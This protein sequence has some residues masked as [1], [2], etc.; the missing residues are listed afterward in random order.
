MY[1]ACGSLS[2]SRS[3]FDA[4]KN[5]DLF[6]Y[7]ALL[8]GYARNAL[9]RDAVSLF[10]DLLFSTELVPD[11]FTLPCV[12]KACAGLTDAELGEAIHALALKSGIFSDAFV[13]N[14]LIA[15][16]GKC[17][18]LQSAVKVFETMPQRNL[19]S[20]N[21][22]MC[23]YTENGDYRECCGVFKGMLSE[24]EGLVPDV[25]TMVT[26]I[27]AYAALGE[28]RV[29]MVLHGLAFKLG[30]SEEVMVNNSLVDMY[31]KC[32]CS[33]DARVLFEMNGGKNVV[34]WNT[35]IGGY[36]KE[37]DFLE[38]FGLLREMQREEKVKVNAVTVLNVLPACSEELLLPS[39]KELHGYAFRHEFQKD[40]LVANAFVAAYAKCGALDCAECVFCGMEGKTVSSWNAL[41][42][43]HAQNG[44]P[45]KALDLYLVMMDSGLDPDQFTIGSLLLACS[46]LKFIRCGKEI[47][48]FMLRNGLELDNF[49]RIS[50]L[51]LYIQCGSMLPAKLIFDK[52]DNKSLVCWNAMITGFSQN[53]LPCEAIDTFCQMLSS[54]IKPQ[55]VAV[56]GV[57][58]ACSRVSALRLGKELH[59]F[60]LKAHLSGDTFVTCALIDMYAKCG[61]M[62]Q[63][64]NIFDRVN[65]KDEAIW[66]V[67]IAGYGI[68]GQGLKAIELFQ[69]MQNK[70]CRPDSF[71][72]LG[73]L[74]AC[75]HAG[76]VTEGLKYLG[77]MQSLYGVKPKVEHYACVVDMLGR[78][79]RLNEALKLVN[80]MPDEPDSGIWSS[81]LSSCRNYGDLEIG[82]EVSKKLLELEPD[83]AENYVL[84]SNL[85][86]GLG[87]WDEVRNVR[88]RMKENRLHK[89]AGCSW[90]EIGG[91][92]YRFVV[93]DGSLLESK[94][95]QQTWIK[96]EKKISNIGYK[97]DTSCVL[98]E[99]EEEEK[100][101]ILK[102]HSE[103]LAISFG[104][105]NTA[106]G[107][108]LRVCKN[109]RICADCHS[110]IKLVSKVVERDIIVR[111]NKRFHHFRHGFCTCGDYW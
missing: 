106:K 109:L 27:P 20:W 39:L 49:I 16:Y 44:F 61:C 105:L 12:V 85:Y 77:Q 52:M 36:S 104:L 11:N 68:H 6:L 55:E 53:E 100:I 5:K 41:I 2:D 37:G 110:A 90:I 108:T 47:H 18:I 23:A 71:T 24:E 21:S 56:T 103:K 92:V 102:S 59:C 32:G 10:S 46:C 84:L 1:S 28:V 9:F 25:A 107:T 73:V 29:G 64:Q 96:L 50:L 65:E 98:H 93:G 72:F 83:K 35:M 101:K 7:N 62:E 30:I 43:A 63:S 67:M 82:E 80:E 60:T 57:L 3:V 79:G 91:K 51:S 8:S 66:N 89:D 70:G 54:G 69:V 45:R 4:A 81:L 94:K 97:P 26:V 99:L 22:M 31:L 17:G 13:G 15:M 14:A 88:Q 33:R 75:N 40:E 95:I 19:V 86:A 42:G 58:G 74:I 76:L 78:A 87:K 48:G 111:D 34:S 38:A